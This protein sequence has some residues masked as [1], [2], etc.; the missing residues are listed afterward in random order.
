MSSAA[1]PQ[2]P[3][4]VD[5]LLAWYCAPHLLEEIRG[6]LH[7]EFDYQVQRVGERQAKRD[8]IRSVLGFIR[9]FAIR[10]KRNEYPSPPVLNFGM[11]H[12]YFTIAFRN[13][14]RHK[15]FSAI[16]IAGLAL[17][18][19]TCLII[20]LF[21]QNEL[22]Y[23]RF[24]EKA[25][26]IVRV[27]FRGSSMGG[28][29]KEAHVMP[30]VAHTLKADYPEVQEATRLRFGGSPVVSYGDKGFKTHFAYADSNFFQ[31]FTLPFVQGNPKTALVQPNTAIISREEARKYFGNQDPMGKILRIKSWNAAFTI[32]GVMEQI[33]VNSHF[34]F[35][36][37]V[38][39][40]S[41]PEAKS[42][43]WMTSE[44]FTYLVLPEG[45]DYRKLEA[46]LPRVVEKYMG[47]QLQQ[48][49]GMSLAQ[50]RQK[51]NDIGLFLQPLTDIHLRSDF[52]YD[53]APG[54]DIQYLYIFG[55]VA[56]FM[57]LIACINFMNLSTAGA[58]KR[59]KE[60]G[61]RKVLGSVK[62]EL[63]RQFLL[64]SL[65]LTTIA[66]LVALVI[67][68]LALPLFNALSGKALSLNFVDHFW[69]GPGL[70]LFG[71]GVGLLSGSY[72]AFFLSSF[73]PVSVLKGKLTTGGKSIGLRSGLIVFQ[74]LVS[75][76][77]MICTTVVY[78]QLQYIQHKKLGYDKDQV[79]VM[80]ETWRLG[81]NEEVFR[82]KLLKDSRVVNVSVSGYLPVG[83]S[84][85]NNFIVYSDEN[86][87]QLV[88][89]LRYGVDYRYIPTLG[90]Q[91]VAGRNFSEAFATDSTGIIINETAAKT[92]GWGN[93][94][95]GHTITHSN[96]EG[97]KVTYR[98]IGIVKDF[99]FKSLH[100]RISPLVMVL[101]NNSGAVIAKVKT[102]DISGLLA[103]LQ[104]QWKEF[105]VEAPFEYSFLKENFEATYQSEQKIGQILGL[106]AG[107]TIF[108]AC[109]GLFGLVT[110][111][112]EQRKKEISIRKVVGASVKDIV[113]LLSKDFLK[114]VLVANG[115]AWPLVYFLM[116]RW[117]AD[118]AY[119]IDIEWWIYGLAAVA[120]LLIAFI[121]VSFQSIRAAL[122]NPVKS[123][124]SE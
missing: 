109:L 87:D 112:A 68:Y 116:N 72:P 24:H 9:P 95:L 74:F 18:I 16:N 61:I 94:A 91:V 81:H 39:M 7:E 53:L 83:S 4:W 89:T 37:F 14:W 100:E 123:L 41:L 6:D 28:P 88:K 106:F 90:M 2:P 75:V 122:M 67:V 97:E 54:G 86:R 8:Y 117:L 21:V 119:R 33:P 38:S 63:V 57:L 12:N 40:A 82:E 34:R 51:G 71:L 69:L 58:T 107:L 121:T 3:R 115:L 99:H 31:V 5:K 96:N 32:T 65:L 50:F 62:G 70:L 108:V 124:R 118:F 76:T 15:A 103:G 20:M 22:S 77:L 80:R 104:N 45:Y 105:A 23:D 30:A 102:K 46:K 113:T 84:N 60:V 52:N 17:G 13:L 92:F 43:S 36:L 73:R 49:M 35:D 66:L 64:E 111:S 120:A 101:G 44:F 114:L 59:A 10:R 42:P 78:R 79:L 19:A 25:N 1:K 55:V 56:L 29:M 27:V 110:F 93:N 98:V 47:P 26:R 85:N 48:A 11:L